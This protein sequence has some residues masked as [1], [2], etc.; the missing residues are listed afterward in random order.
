MEKPMLIPHSKG[1]LFLVPKLTAEAIAII[2]FGSVV[3]DA[4]I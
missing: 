3:T 4:E 1:K 2:V